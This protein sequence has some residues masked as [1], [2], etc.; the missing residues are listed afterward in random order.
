MKTTGTTLAPE[1]LK[2]EQ[3]EALRQPRGDPNPAWSH[4]PHP[5]V[6]VCEPGLVTR[7]HSHGLPELPA[8]PSAVVLGVPALE[9]HAFLEEKLPLGG[10]VAGKGGLG[11][12]CPNVV[13]RMGEVG[14]GKLRE[15]FYSRAHSAS[16]PGGSKCALTALA[17]ISLLPPHPH[18]VC[19]CRG[20]CNLT[21]GRGIFNSTRGFL[22]VRAA[23]PPRSRSWQS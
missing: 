12:I 5:T 13:V 23:A 17:A 19:V 18:C 20:C 16:P 7:S 3:G 10:G 4:Q 22:T 8:E 9:K 2:Q 21:R 11:N 1:A 14:P 15:N 6:S